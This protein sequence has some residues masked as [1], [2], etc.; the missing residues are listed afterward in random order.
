MAGYIGNIPVPQGTQTRQSFTATA[1]QT[2]FPTIG[3]T[4][5]FIDVYLNGVKLIDGTDFTAT[6]GS[7]VVLTVGASASDVLN[8]V[9]FDTF[10]ALNQTFTDSI[11]VEGSGDFDTAVVTVENTTKENTEGGRESRLRFRGFK[12]GDVAPHTLAEIQGSH[13]GTANDQKG[14]LIF[15]TNDGSDNAAPTEAMRITSDQRLGIGTNNP[16]T[17]VTIESDATT[18]LKIINNNADN[19]GARMT[20]FKNSASPADADTIGLIDFNGNNSSG[21]GKVFNRISS[22]VD[23]VTAGTE[24]SHIAFSTRSAGTLEEVLSIHRYGIKMGEGNGIDFHNY[25]SGTN[26][27]SNFLD[28]YEEG[29]WTPTFSSSS[30]ATGITVNNAHYVK[31][32]DLVNVTAAVAFTGTTGNYAVGDNYQIGGLPFSM[33]DT[34]GRNGSGWASA[35]SNRIGFNN[36]A[37]LTY[38]SGNVTSVY[39]T[40]ARTYA[41][42]ITITYKISAT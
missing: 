2:S 27:S 29:T 15:K 12:S 10:T 40:L 32:G 39:G 11:S 37:Q 26:I 35:S 31:I 23:D 41:V 28:D 8:V 3:Y 1:S 16:D 4:A 38:I 18:Q 13:D 21:S 25:S 24:D 22:L 33:S 36:L 5:G 42:T 14:D 30:F 34:H 7:D 20:F 17:Q 6:N 9:I 19:N